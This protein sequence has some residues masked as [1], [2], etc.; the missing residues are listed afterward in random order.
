MNILIP[1]ALGVIPSLVWLAYYLRKD[2]HPELKR[3]IAV[4]FLLGMAVTPFVVLIQ[5]VLAYFVYEQNLTPFWRDL[6]IIFFATALIEEYFKYLAVRIAI[7]KNPEFDEPVDAMIYMIVAALGFAAVENILLV[8]SFAPFYEKT[9]E[10]F[11]ILILRFAGATF[12]HALASGAL[13]YYLALSFFHAHKKRRLL[14]EGLALATLLHGF[15]NYFIIMYKGQTVY[16]LVYLIIL[17]IIV[18]QYFKTLKNATS[19]CEVP[20]I[21]K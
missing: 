17:S 10:A 18:A 4:V 14:L 19:I 13:G 11:S 9:G 12:L 1:I 7:Y 20:I 2:V 8:Y 21:K 3:W 6:A 16:V 5:W 15:F